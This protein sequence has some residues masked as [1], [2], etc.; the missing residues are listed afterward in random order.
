M[1]NHYF[2]DMD[3]GRIIHAGDPGGGDIRRNKQ[4]LA[5]AGDND[6]AYDQ[7]DQF[8]KNSPVQPPSEEPP[9]QQDSPFS[10]RF[11]FDDED[12][13]VVEAPLPAPAEQAQPEIGA[14][15]EPENLLRDQAQEPRNPSVS[16]D[17]SSS[18]AQPSQPQPAPKKQG[19]FGRIGAG[20]KRM[21]SG[22]RS[23]FGGGRA[24]PA[25]APQ[26]PSGQWFDDERP[27]VEQQLKEKAAT[28]D[29][30]KHRRL[31]N[32]K[33][34]A[35]TPFAM[36]P[37]ERA[38]LA[39]I[40]PREATL[41]TNDVL[42]L[43]GAEAENATMTDREVTRAIAQG[44]PYEQNPL[45]GGMQKALKSK[46]SPDANPESARAQGVEHLP[47]RYGQMGLVTKKF[48][49]KNGGWDGKRHRAEGPGAAPNAMLDHATDIQ[50][51]VAPGDPLF[52]QEPKPNLE[53]S[54]Q[55]VPAQ[56]KA[57]MGTVDARMYNS[58]MARM[59]AE[60][61]DRKWRRNHDHWRDILKN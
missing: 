56:P 59:K 3:G 9:A 58:M 5:N 61:A 57:Q 4:Q 7:A 47:G 40:K 19:F 48:F 51:D 34:E 8:L 41:P 35:Y 26:A 53:Q 28:A 15:D 27:G 20:L 6:D 43:R 29:V 13:P 21:W 60:L 37:S 23:L 18:L 52:D 32:G 33:W 24:A 25:S 42:Q 14:G 30:V 2:E 50:D 11:R 55:S 17:R 54:A 22:I 31:G 49:E 44:R 46:E 36:N 12:S 45:V 1:S 10:D 16:M 38:A 39:D